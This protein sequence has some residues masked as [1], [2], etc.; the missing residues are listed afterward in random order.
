LGVSRGVAAA[1]HPQLWFIHEKRLYLFLSA[2]TR[3]RFSADP[4]ALHD[5]AEEKWPDVLRELVP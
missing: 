1:G 2:E 5:V 4:D 3:E